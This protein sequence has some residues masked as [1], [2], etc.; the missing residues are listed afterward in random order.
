[1]MTFTDQRKLAL[2][3]TATGWFTLVFLSGWVG[4]VLVPL[5]IISVFSF[6]SIKQYQMVFEPTLA[7]WT[8]LFESGRWTV[9]AR[10]LQFAVT[11]TL[12]ELLLAFPFALWL[13]KGCRSDRVRA[14]IITLLTIPF[15]LDA[16]SRI[17][18]WRS[19]LGTNGVINTLLINAGLIDQ[20]I[21]W[22]LY[23]GFAVHFGM[24]GSYFPSAVFPI[25]LTISLI[26]DDLIK[27]SAD[28]GASARQTLFNIIL[29]LAMP[30][31]I[32]GA[33]FTVVPLM[34]AWVEPQLLGGGQ[35]NLLGQSIQSALSN[36]NYP[37]AAALSTIVIVILVLLLSVLTFSLRGRMNMA[38][39]F[40]SHGH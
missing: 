19:I 15:F 28:L 14:L 13:A 6:F 32:G 10:T 9:V 4:I 31:I 39:I 2:P 35:V 26:D 3:K 33:I 22:L 12:I 34:A 5:L 37:V 38:S 25:F 36:L 23:S 8:G 17:I 11:V 30:G 7:T 40:Q 27:A 16:S 29:P 21:T 18:V 1:M 24:I 20:P